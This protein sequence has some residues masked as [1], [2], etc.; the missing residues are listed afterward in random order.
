MPMIHSHI[1]SAP[2]AF[3][4]AFQEYPSHSTVEICTKFLAASI[5]VDTMEAKNKVTAARRAMIGGRL[6]LRDIK[7][8]SNRP[9]PTS[10]TP[11]QFSPW[12]PPKPLAKK[13]FT[14]QTLFS[15]FGLDKYPISTAPGGVFE[16]SDM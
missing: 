3:P 6:G 4:M 1:T 10:M 13:L 9:S 12:A 7:S 15:H 5:E 2:Y 8:T 14:V 16:D 11:F